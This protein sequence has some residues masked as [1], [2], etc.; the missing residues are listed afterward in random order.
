MNNCKEDVTGIVKHVNDQAE[1]YV[2]PCDGK[3][4]RDINDSHDAANSNSSRSVNLAYSGIDIPSLTK[5]IDDRVD[6]KLRKL[7]DTPSTASSK[8]KLFK[9]V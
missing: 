2:L 6:T 3:K 1:T 9:T 7:D 8:G 4:R 5:L